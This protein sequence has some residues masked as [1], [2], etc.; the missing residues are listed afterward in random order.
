MVFPVVMYRCE[1]WIIKKADAFELWCWRRLFVVVVK[2][3]LIYSC[4]GSSLLHTGFLYLRRVGAI[5]CSTQVSH[6]GG[7]SCC[8]ARALD[9]QTSVA[10]VL[11]HVGSSQT[12]D[13]TYVPCIGRQEVLEK[14]L[15]SPLDSKQIKPVNPKG[16]QPWICTGMTDAEAEAPILWPLIQRSDS[17]Q[18]ILMLGKIEGRRKK[19][20]QRMRWLDQHNGHE[21]KQTLGGSEG[22]RSLVCCTQSMGLQRVRHN[23]VAEQLIV[24]SSAPSMVPLQINKIRLFRGTTFILL[25]GSLGIRL[26][27]F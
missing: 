4:T 2:F 22:Q 1:R 24:I 11:R 27:Y 5:L 23:W 18:K 26:L 10:V 12:R 17:L 16:S 8:R 20:R 15:E 3:L 7:F 13:Q 25:S 6:W 9:T 19:G 21:F 14:I